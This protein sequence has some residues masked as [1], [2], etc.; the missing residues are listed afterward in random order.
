MYFNKLE[1]AEVANIIH[2][3][4]WQVI[5]VSLYKTIGNGYHRNMIIQFL[6][7]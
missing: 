1:S 6:S 5:N 4:D 2:L 7:K 3:I